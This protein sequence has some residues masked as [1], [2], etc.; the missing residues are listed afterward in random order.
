MMPIGSMRMRV[1]MRMACMS[2][3]WAGVRVAVVSAGQQVQPAVPQ[4]GH[5]CKRSQ[6]ER[7]QRPSEHHTLTEPDTGLS[8]APTGKSMCHTDSAV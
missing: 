1:S 7:T 5:R 3:R 6:Q 8:T 2:G 4:Q